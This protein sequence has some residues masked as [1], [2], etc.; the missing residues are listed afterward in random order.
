MRAVEE[1]GKRAIPAP[2]DTRNESHCRKIVEEAVQEFGQI[3]VLVNKVAYQTIHNGIREISSEQFDRTFET[4]VYAMFLTTG[5]KGKRG[6]LRTGMDPAH[7]DHLPPEQGVSGF[8][9]SQPIGRLAQPVEVAPAY[10]FLTSGEAVAPK[11]AGVPRPP[12]SPYLPGC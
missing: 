4:N 7:T 12:R 8:G 2:G 3:D 6:R 5:D 10:V 11:G 1:L 9:Q